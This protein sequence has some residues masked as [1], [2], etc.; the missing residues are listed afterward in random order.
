V[1]RTVRRDPGASRYELVEDGRV[2]G[3]ADYQERADVVVL[4]HTLIEPS[5]QGDGLG[6]ELV[7]AVLDDLRTRGH[8]VVPA[9]WYVQE[10]IDGHPAYQDLV[11][12]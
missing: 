5:R 4:P 10:F 2:I 6:A 8:R 9:C 12:G 3:F 11:A 7:A 1:S